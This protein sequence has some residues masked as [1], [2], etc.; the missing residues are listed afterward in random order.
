MPPMSLRSRTDLEQAEAEYK[1]NLEMEEKLDNKEA[2]A[3]IYGY[4][5]DIC[6]LRLDLDQA[7]DMYKKGLELFEAT[8]ATKMIEIMNTMLTNLSK[9]PR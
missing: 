5:G 7:E 4:L 9:S 3:T 1:K 2:M 8:G 6:R